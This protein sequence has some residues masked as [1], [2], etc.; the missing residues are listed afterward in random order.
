MNQRTKQKLNQDHRKRLDK[1]HN[2]PNGYLEL[3]AL[4]NTDTSKSKEFVHVS[5]SL[6]VAD[7]IVLNKDNNYEIKFST[8]LQEGTGITI[9]RTGTVI[10][11]V[12]EGSY[13]FEIC[14]E[15]APFSD[16]DISLIYYSDEFSPEIIPFTITKIPKDQGMIHLR[17]IPSILPVQKNQN[18]VV[19]LIAEPDESI[20]LLGG[21]RLMIHRVA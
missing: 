13:Q 20:V 6:L 14:G 11:F 19:K 7:N 12:Q 8:G 9:N 4:P 1:K 18:I 21:T 16:I 15:A 10:T 3:W 2:Y 5:T 17:G